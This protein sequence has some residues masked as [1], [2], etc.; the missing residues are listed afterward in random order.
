MT[1]I[2]FLDT[3]KKKEVRTLKIFEKLDINPTNINLYYQAF[4]HS[5]Y[6]NENP[7]YA[8]YERLEFLGDAVLEIII[9]DYLY[10]ARHLEEGTM[11]KMRAN[12]VCEKACATYAKDLNFE[13]DIKLGNNEE[14]NDT[15]LADVFEAFIGAIYLD[16]GFDFAMKF[17]ME[18]ILPYIDNGVNFLID[19]K[20]ELQEKVQT[21]KKSV[22]YEVVEE[23]GPAHNKK[24]TSVVKVDGIILGKGK[25][26]SKKISEQEAAKDALLKEV[27]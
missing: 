17:A 15:I 11:T 23:T 4:T 25:G 18:I 24:F 6:T 3:I 2:I 20:S 14:V 8:N 7:G 19:Y 9:S 26:S 10:K 16:K 27:K 13:L 12:Y 1:I 5:S 22:V 21:V